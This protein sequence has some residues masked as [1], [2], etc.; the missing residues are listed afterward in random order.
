M[1]VIAYIF[2]L[3]F[4]SLSSLNAQ[5]NINVIIPKPQMFKTVEGT[6]VLSDKTH[7]DTTTSLASDAIDYLQQQLQ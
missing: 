3:L 5:T 4:L 2:L 7:Y 6:F 1:K